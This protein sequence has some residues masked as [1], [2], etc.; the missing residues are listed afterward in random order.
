[1]SKS[2]VPKKPKKHHPLIIGFVIFVSAMALVTVGS[3]IYGKYQNHQRVQQLH[4]TDKDLQKFGDL[5][6]QSF[7]GLVQREKYCRHDIDKLG[8]GALRCITKINIKTVYPSEEVLVAN[9][10]ILNS[11]LQSQVWFSANK[12]FTTSTDNER[13]ITLSSVAFT[14][15]KTKMVCSASNNVVHFNSIAIERRGEFNFSVHC[16]TDALQK[17][18]YK[19]ED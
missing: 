6:E 17:P 4:E 13:V 10:N 18:V 15:K 16:T 11:L 5:L 19:L 2:K 12:I 3:F 1:M 7:P 9:I 8:E 14:N